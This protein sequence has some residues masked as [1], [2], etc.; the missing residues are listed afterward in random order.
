MEVSLGKYAPYAK[1][2]AA[3]IA[4]L[5]PFLTVVGTSLADGSVSVEEGIAVTT[6]FGALVGGTKAVYQVKNKKVS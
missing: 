5:I 6:A 1:T 2:V 3:F 4:L